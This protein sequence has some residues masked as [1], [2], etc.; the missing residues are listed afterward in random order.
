M[1]FRHTYLQRKMTRPF[2]RFLYTCFLISAGAPQLFSQNVSPRYTPVAEADAIWNLERAGDFSDQQIVT[3]L[4]KIK[5]MP[6][7]LWLKVLEL[8]REENR[9]VLRDFIIVRFTA[10]FPYFQQSDTIH[11]LYIQ[12]LTEE[13]ARLMAKDQPT[14]ED[15][16]RLARLLGSISRSNLQE[17]FYQTSALIAYPLLEVRR[18]ANETLTAIKDDRV[19]PIVLRL[20]ESDN[21]VERTYA[22]DSLFYLKDDRTLPVLLQLLNDKN[23]SVR[24]YCIRT[25]DA[26]NMQ[27][28]IPYY[29]RI[30]RS[31]VNNEVRILTIRILAKSKP[32]A[33]YNTLLELL[34]DPAADVRKSALTTLNEY[35]NINSAFFISRQLALETERELK[36]MEIKS[37]ISLNN[38]GQ[39]AGLSRILREEA[40]EEVLTW[41]IYAVGKIADAGGYELLL[42]K[43]EHKSF[44]VREE[45][46]MALGSFK[47]RK[48]VPLLMKIIAGKE[49]PFS[50]QSAALYAMEM[51]DDNSAFPELF[52]LSLSHDNPAIRAEIRSVLKAMIDRRFK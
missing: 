12:L 36:I 49:E 18:A 27:E 2:F 4:E 30:L 10:N 34:S 6:E 46:A 40:D 37:L 20:A 32:P 38:T 50:L 35:N 39:M 41:A 23:K 15:I 1:V 47:V 9:Q 19:F 29:I 51:I 25:L 22:I 7:K 33:A 44:G 13:S 26:L 3:L 17:M 48:S 11:R 5:D 21:P 43:L 14:D 42:D 52:N 16:T 24:Y 28:A 45:A 31:D 8:A